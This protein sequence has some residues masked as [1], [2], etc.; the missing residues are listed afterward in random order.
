MAKSDF[1]VIG[2]G[3]FGTQVAKS[4]SANDYNVILIDND[5]EKT[6]L[7]SKEFEY[8]FQA[9]ATDLNTLE[10]LN[11][12]EVD[13]VI[14]SVSNIE[15][16]IMIA[17]NLKELKVK[18]IIARAKNL[19]HKRVLNTI[20]VKEAVIPEEVVGNNIAMKMIHKSNADI[21]TLGKTIS[22]VKSSLTNS[23]LFNK[24]LSDINIRAYAG[25]NIISIQRQDKLIFPVDADTT[26]MQAD[27]ISV[28]CKSDEIDE[29]LEFINPTKK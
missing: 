11:I 10:E 19:I 25:A 28:V 26:L 9:D 15:S 4:L 20:G 7:A 12:S 14:V 27:F 17:A 2:L 1:C 8:V 6:K 23:K 22:I 5:E 29:Y 24:K 18:N 16:S 3:R 13:T 21:V